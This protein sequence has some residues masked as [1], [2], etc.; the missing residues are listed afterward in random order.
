MKNVRQV[1]NDEERKKSKRGKVYVPKAELYAMCLLAIA[2]CRWVYQNNSGYSLYNSSIHVFPLSAW[3]FAFF[4]SCA[5][6]RVGGLNMS[7][8]C[9][10]SFL[11]TQFNCMQF[12]SGTV[13]K[14][15]NYISSLPPIVQISFS[16]FDRNCTRLGCH[17]VNIRAYSLS[18]ATMDTAALVRIFKKIDCR[19]RFKF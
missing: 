17:M 8:K 11:C 16:S 12:G 15:E 3:T 6:N 10:R 9:W 4:S 5:A 13:A 7:K 14:L 2:L 18:L 19:F 1:K